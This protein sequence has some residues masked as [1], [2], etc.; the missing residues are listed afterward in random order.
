MNMQTLQNP[1]TFPRPDFG[2]VQRHR[3][4]LSQSAGSQIAGVLREQQL[5]ILDQVYRVDAA[6]IKTLDGICASLGDVDIEDYRVAIRKLD[7]EGRTDAENEA[8]LS[9]Q[10]ELANDMNSGVVTTRGYVDVLSSNLSSLLAAALA[11]TREQVVHAQSLLSSAGPLLDEP[12]TRHLEFLLEDLK[13]PLHMAAARRE[14]VDEIDKILSPLRFF[15]DNVLTSGR[16]VIQVADEFQKQV[17]E[18]L[19]YLRDIRNEWKG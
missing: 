8:F 15:C 12:Q 16:D 9:Y 1:Y 11:D 7:H 18:L 2:A 3:K 10:R 4:V 13:G 5:A 6:I 17:D 19:S 14:Y